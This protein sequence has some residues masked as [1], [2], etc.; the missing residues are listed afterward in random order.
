VLLKGLPTNY[1]ELQKKSSCEKNKQFHRCPAREQWSRVRGE[2]SKEGEG[3]GRKI[4]EGEQ[5]G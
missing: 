5:M 2:E 1:Y 4:I 3:R